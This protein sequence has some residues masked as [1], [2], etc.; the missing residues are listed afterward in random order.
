MDVVCSF[1]IN[2]DL[3]GKSSESALHLFSVV[4]MP[5]VL[6]APWFSTR[7]FTM[8]THAQALANNVYPTPATLPPGLSLADVVR[9][10]ALYLNHKSRTM[11]RTAASVIGMYM[12]GLDETSNKV[13]LEVCIVL[14]FNVQIAA[15]EW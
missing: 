10:L 2:P 8:L 3:S 9:G 12:Q 1:A 7:V 11:A 14:P 15:H 13:G 6:C 4:S 5:D